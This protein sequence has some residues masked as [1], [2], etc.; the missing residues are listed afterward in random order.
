MKVLLS[1]ILLFLPLVVVAQDFN[2]KDYMFIINSIE[3]KQSITTY[4]FNMYKDTHKTKTTLEVVINNNNE[5]KAYII[6]VNNNKSIVTID[7]NLFI[8]ITNLNKKRH[9]N[10]TRN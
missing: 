7:D 2:S 10:S 6:D 1:I 4:T 8:L 9:D 3:T 5:Y